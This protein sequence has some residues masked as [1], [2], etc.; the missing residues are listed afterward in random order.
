MKVI[1]IAGGSGAGKSTV[2]YELIDS[3]PAHFEVLNLDDY[4]KVGNSG[5]LPIVE[6]MKNWDHPD[7]VDW[8][9][10]RRDIAALRAGNAVLLNVWAH[11]SN[12]DF[13]HTRQRIPRVVEPK[14]IMIVEGY[15]ALYDAMNGIYDQSFYL[16]LDEGT[17][18]ERRKQARSGNDSLSGNPH[19]N[20]LIL[21]PM[22]H[23]YV[24]PTKSRADVVINVRD[25]TA[26]D[27]ARLIR[28][29]LVLEG[30]DSSVMER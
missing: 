3:D 16:D 13:A 1:A 25:R 9:I 11:R 27:I 15:L 7:A 14:A 5:S 17:R 6:G 18:L 28:S 22:H 21:Q 20:D 4:Q 10:L 26:A 29:Y 30:G 19:Y 2:S 12:T 23:L 8:N 24:E